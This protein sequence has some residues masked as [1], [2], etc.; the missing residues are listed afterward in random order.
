MVPPDSA[1]APRTPAYSGTHAIQT[2]DSSPTGLSPAPVDRSRSLRLES[3]AQTGQ[4]PHG[5]LNPRSAS[6]P[7]LGSSPFARRYSGNLDLIS[8]PPGT[9]MF[10]F[11]GLALPCRSDGVLSPPGFPIRTSADQWMRAPPRSFSQLATSFLAG[12]RQGIPRELLHRLATL[13]PKRKRQPSPLSPRRSLLLS[14][15]PL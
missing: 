10:Q 4:T 11:P 3:E 15:R 2:P 5:P 1:R 8:L 14:Q 13:L 7:G 9:E 12:L 6:T